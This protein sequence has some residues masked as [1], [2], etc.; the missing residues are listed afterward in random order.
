AARCDPRSAGRRSVLGDERALFA[1]GAARL[2]GAD[3]SSSPADPR[4]R[5][6]KA[7]EIDASD[8]T[9]RAARARRHAGR[10]PQIGRTR[11]SLSRAIVPARAADANRIA[12][13][14]IA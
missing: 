10:N 13:E 14:T 9:A 5:R 12:H 4:F 1:A 2:A 6:Q 7:R 3:L 11:L 8:G